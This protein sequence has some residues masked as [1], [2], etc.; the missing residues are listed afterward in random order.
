MSAEVQAAHDRIAAMG[1]AVTRAVFTWAEETAA[2]ASFS[3]RLKALEALAGGTL[4]QTVGI[5]STAAALSSFL[6]VDAQGAAPRDL[7]K[8][9]AR[10]ICADLDAVLSYL[11]AEAKSK[12]RAHLSVVKP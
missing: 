5:A 2:A 6:V 4:P 10:A 1:E 9:R 12:K 3:E 11:E 8:E 7:L